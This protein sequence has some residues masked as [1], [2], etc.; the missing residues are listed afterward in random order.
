MLAPLIYPGDT[1]L[2]LDLFKCSLR[3]DSIDCS[4]IYMLG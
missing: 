3:T 4:N 2:P 1:P